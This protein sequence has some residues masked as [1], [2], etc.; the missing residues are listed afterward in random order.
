MKSIKIIAYFFLSFAVLI[1]MSLPSAASAQAFAQHSYGGYL[2]TIWKIFCPP[3]HNPNPTPYPTHP[4]HHGGGT[5]PANVNRFASQLIDYTPPYTGEPPNVQQT[6][7]GGATK[8][9]GAPQRIVHTSDVNFD[10]VGNQPGYVIVGFNSNVAIANGSGNDLRIH[11][12]DANEPFE[13]FVSSDGVTYT[14]IGARN[15]Q[16]PA[17]QPYTV[18]FNIGGSNVTAVRYIKI[19]NSNVVPT[20]NASDPAQTNEGPDI[21][22][23]RIL[24]CAGNPTPTATPHPTPTPTSTPYPTPTPCGYYCPTPTPTSTPTPTPTYTPTPTATPYPTPTYNPCHYNNCPT[25]TPDNYW[26]DKPE[27]QNPFDDWESSWPSQHNNSDWW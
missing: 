20:V 27:Y 25:P 4:P 8:V 23:I 26:S 14:S 22:A 24:N 2:C 19:V 16:G 15:P 21:D 18:D 10:S 6:V 7:P 3:S 17:L 1:S 5:C 13:V 11:L 9:L 12:N